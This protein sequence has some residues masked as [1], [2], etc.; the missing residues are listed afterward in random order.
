ME[1]T[2]ARAPIRCPKGPEPGREGWF[3]SSSA[4]RYGWLA[5]K[6]F[7]PLN[8]RSLPAHPTKAIFQQKLPKMMSESSWGLLRIEFDFN[9]RLR[10]NDISN[11]VNNLLADSF[12]GKFALYAIQM[13][14]REILNVNGSGRNFDPLRHGRLQ[15]SQRKSIAAA[16]RSRRRRWDAVLRLRRPPHGHGHWIASS[17]MARRSRPCFKGRVRGSLDLRI[18]SATLGSS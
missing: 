17:L 13:P 1:D 7:S 15:P 18:G 3:A 10:P 8:C 9:S 16:P 11:S 5:S 2:L 12:L 6:S 14:A 4:S